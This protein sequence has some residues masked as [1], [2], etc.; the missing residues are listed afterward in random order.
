[1]TIHF[2]TSGWRAVIA[3]EFTFAAVG[4]VTEAICSQFASESGRPVV[5]AHDTRF[6]GEVFAAECAQII[7]E[8]GFEALVCT[9]PTP[10]PTVS[11][12]IRSQHAVC[13][14][15]FTASHNPPE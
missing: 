10:T 15:N 2:G 3:D 6:L 8:Q 4:R 11:H 14:I 12:A 9:G 5:V 7:V 1:M 13:G